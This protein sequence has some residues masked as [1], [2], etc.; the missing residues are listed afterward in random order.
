MRY[1]IVLAAVLAA[2]PALAGAPFTWGPSETKP[3]V[4]SA[5]AAATADDRQKTADAEGLFDAGK[6]D[7]AIEAA[8][9]LQ[10]GAKDEA[11]RTDA[12][13]L[14]AEALRRKGDWKAA[15]AAYLK[16]RD[17]FEK[18]SDDYARYDAVSEVLRASPSGVYAP[19]AAAAGGKTLA[20]DQV[21]ADALVR[22]AEAR[23]EKLK[24]RIPA[25]KRARTPQ[26]VVALFTALAEEFRQAR[27]VAPMVSPEA[28][29]QAAQAAA[30]RLVELNKP[31]LTGLTAKQTEFQTAITTR[32]LTANQRKEMETC[33]TACNELEKNED[34]FL[35][36]LDNV[37]GAAGW[38][39]GSQ[40]RSASTERKSAY[41]R[42]APTFT[43]PMTRRTG[44]NMDWGSIWAW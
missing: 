15:S 13:R 41:T 18:G 11:A 24:G 34:A 42:M 17:R 31:I 20:D 10:R 7:E 23:I 29:Q 5:G 14:V 6:Y 21:L 12:T 1:A 40:A 19:T 25:L 8:R 26:E 32:R 28:E 33:K 38:A 37:G 30:E 44:D 36:A 35:A 22:V 2:G 9:V 43:P 27:A 4:P 39:A 3:A 16:L